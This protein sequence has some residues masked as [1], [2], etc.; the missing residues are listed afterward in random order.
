MED[1]VIRPTSFRVYD[2]SL[3]GKYLILENIDGYIYKD[4]QLSPG[5]ENVM[6][7]MAT[8]VKDGREYAAVVGD[9]KTREDLENFLKNTLGQYP[10]QEERVDGYYVYVAKGY[11]QK[12]YFWTYKTFFI[13]VLEHSAIAVPAGIGRAVPVTVPEEVPTTIA[14][15]LKEQEVLGTPQEAPEFLTG[16]ITGMPGAIGTELKYCGM[17]SLDPNCVCRA[18]ETKEGFEP[19]CDGG[20]CGKHYRCKQPR[21]EELLVAYLD[22]Y[23]SDIRAT[24]TQCE[25]KG[26]YCISTESSCRPGFEEVSFSCKTSEEKCC[27]QEVD[28]DDFLEM[29]MKLEGIR[30]RMDKLERQARALAEYYDS[31]E[32]SERANKF[33]EVAGMF[34]H[35]K[36]MIDDIIAKIRENLSNLD[37]IRNEVKGDIKELRIYISSILEEMVT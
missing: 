37:A 34:A 23:P 6:G 20:I 22:K 11:G 10:A 27:I 25:Q 7:Y 13:G 35:A 1:Y 24:G 28:R 18:D 9:F 21:P 32:D 19:P 15:P 4:A 30:V 33:R 12:V 3:L 17:D 26:G 5:P 29:V 2:Y 8:Y 31:V 16:M 36:E 14:V